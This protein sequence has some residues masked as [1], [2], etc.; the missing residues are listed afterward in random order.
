MNSTNRQNPMSETG[1]AGALVLLGEGP[2][3]RDWALLLATVA[4]SMTP[5][6]R[7]VSS[8][9]G[10][11][12]G[13]P[14]AAGPF[15]PIVVRCLCRVDL[16]VALT[17][18]G[19]FV[20]DD[21][22]EGDFDSGDESG[23]DGGGGIADDGD[24]EGSAPDPAGAAAAPADEAAAP[25]SLLPCERQ[26][27]VR[28][29]CAESMSGIKPN[30]FAQRIALD[31]CT[32]MSGR[33]TAPSFPLLSSKGAK[34]ATGPTPMPSSPRSISSFRFA[35]FGKSTDTC[36]SSAGHLAFPSRGAA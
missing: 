32:T 17:T 1:F 3:P 13:E 33:R 31:S 36:V 29:C 5:V 4:W 8:K 12:L 11:L 28:T 19:C 6:S 21:A 26:K 25:P 34:C 16:V 2:A 7:R 14:R 22:F 18:A 30:S 24:E 15:R 35:A 20:G 10:L 23:D 27:I 9:F